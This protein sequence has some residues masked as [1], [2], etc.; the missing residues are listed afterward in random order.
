MTQ[1]IARLTLPAQDLARTLLG[2]PTS[3]SIVGSLPGEGVGTVALIV[4]SP[5]LGETPLPLKAEITDEGSTRTVRLV[6]DLA[7]LARK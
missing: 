2:I 1:R 6:P 4:T 3:Y 7:R 5:D